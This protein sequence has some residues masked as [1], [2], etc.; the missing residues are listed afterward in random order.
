MTISRIACLF[1]SLLA[2]AGCGFQPVYG[3]RD[4]ADSSAVGL[5]LN[6]I[7]IENIPDR[8]GQILRND[9]IDRMYGKNRPE[10]PLYHLKVSIH[11]SQESLGVLSNATS[12]RALLNMYSDYTLTDARGQ[13]I[14]EGKA[15]SVASFDTFDAVYSSVVAQ[16][17]AYQRTLHEIGEQIVNRLSLYFG[18]R[19]EST[20]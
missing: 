10:S 4:A 7:V 14:L 5:D 3:S 13:E 12:T 1:F 8:N 17:D 15:Y 18:Q 11:S 6:N 20:P 16:Q 9:L 19:Q 2:L